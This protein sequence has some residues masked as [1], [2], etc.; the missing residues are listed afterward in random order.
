MNRKNLLES[1]SESVNNELRLRNEY[2]VAENRIL[3]N[4]MDGRAQLTDSERKE[5]AEL[6]ARQHDGL[7]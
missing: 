7:A 6:G 3:R 2:L 1:V 5:F 4:Q